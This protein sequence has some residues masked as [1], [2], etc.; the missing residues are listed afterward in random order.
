MLS[1]LSPSS[2]IFENLTV[3]GKIIEEIVSAVNEIS[4]LNREES[5]I[6]TRTLYLYLSANGVH[7]TLKSKEGFLYAELNHVDLVVDFEGV[8]RKSEFIH[9]LAARRQTGGEG[10]IGHSGNMPVDKQLLKKL[11]EAEFA[12]VLKAH[13]PLRHAA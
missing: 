3:P 1:D 4:H 11:E 7:A 2:H 9:K 6:V 13:L 8:Q 10:A 5:N 12:L